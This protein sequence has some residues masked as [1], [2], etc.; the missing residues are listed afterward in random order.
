MLSLLILMP[1]LILLYS[2]LLRRRRN[3]AARFGN[4]WLSAISAGSQTA[5]ASHFPP[6]L[7]LT[8]LA[9]LIVGLARPQAEVNLPRIEGTVILA[10]DVSGSMAAEDQEPNRMEA[11]KALARDFVQRQPST[12]QIGVVAFSNSGFSVQAPTN[13]QNAILAAINRLSPQQGTSLGQGIF[14]ALNTLNPNVPTQM[15]RDGIPIPTPRPTPMPEGAY[16]S[17]VMILLSDGENLEPPDP[18]EAAQAAAEQGV[19]IYPV[20]IG[21]PAGISLN[22]NGFTVHTRLE[23]TVL[24][25]IAQVSG[26]EYFNAQDEQDLESIYNSINLQLVTK[27]EKTEITSILAGIS[28]VILLVG[29]VLFFGGR[30]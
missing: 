3:Q 10:F 7:F 15:D 24:Q 26:G 30:R 28:L 8:S 19:R 16:S 5:P 4:L 6:A 11:A 17:T 27:P 12:I 1:V 9:L 25:Q 22:V 2:L 13:D 23:E 18:L 20:G 29:G 14:S 21:S